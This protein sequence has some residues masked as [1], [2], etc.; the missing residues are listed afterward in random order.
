MNRN[1]SKLLD[2]IDFFLLISDEHDWDKLSYDLYTKITN[3]YSYLSDYPLEILT[4][5][6]DYYIMCNNNCGLGV[7]QYKLSQKSK[8]FIKHIYSEYGVNLI[9]WSKYY[10]EY[11][12]STITLWP[13]SHRIIT[14]ENGKRICR[15]NL[16]VA[17]NTFEVS[18]VLNKLSDSNDASNQL[19]K[20]KAILVELLRELTRV[21]SLMEK[22]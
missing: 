18:N 6:K 17:R 15:Y 2:D 19:R 5:A 8:K 4:F 16:N 22:R 14:E 13:V 3:K 11:F 1:L 20:N 10:L 7:S 12:Y 9:V 21:H